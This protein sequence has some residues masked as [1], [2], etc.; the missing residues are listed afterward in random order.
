MALGV[1]STALS[2]ER[3]ER[4]G[5]YAKIL[6]T[7]SV[8]KRDVSRTIDDESDDFYKEGSC[9]ERNDWTDEG[10][11]LLEETLVTKSCN[12]QSSE[13]GRQV[14]NEILGSFSGLN[15][16]VYILKSI[17]SA[18]IDK[19]INFV[20]VISKIDE[21]MTLPKAEQG[22]SNTTGTYW[23]VIGETNDVPI[24]QVM[25]ET[26]EVAKHI[27]DEVIKNYTVEQLASVPVSCVQEKIEEM[28][29]ITLQEQASKRVI[30]QTADILDQQIQESIV[31][32]MK[33]ISLVQQTMEGTVDVPVSQIWKETEKVHPDWELDCL[34]NYVFCKVMD[35]LKRAHDLWFHD[36]VKRVRLE[37]ILEK[38]LEEVRRKGDEPRNEPQPQVNKMQG[39][40][41][42]QL[43]P[44]RYS[45]KVEEAI[46]QEY[47]HQYAEEQHIPM[48]IHTG[49]IQLAE[50]NEFESEHENQNEEINPMTSVYRAGTCVSGDQHNV[51]GT[52]FR[53]KPGVE[54]TNTH[55]HVTHKLNTDTEHPLRSSQHDKTLMTQ[56]S[57]DDETKGYQGHSKGGERTIYVRRQGEMQAMNEQELRREASRNND[58][59]VVYDGKVVSPRAIKYLKNHAIAHVVDKLRGGGRKKNQ[60]KMD[61]T[62]ND[63]SGSSLSEAD[64]FSELLEKFG[65]SNEL[66][67]AML[68]VDDDTIQELMN[69]MRHI[70]EA[71]AGMNR[72]AALD[73]LQRMIKEHRQRA[74]HQQ[75]EAAQEAARRQKQEEMT[76][77][78]DQQGKSLAES[79]EQTQEVRHG[80]KQE[81]T[82]R[83]R[84]QQKQRHQ[85]ARSEVKIG[86]GR[87]MGKTYGS[88]YKEDPGY[89]E[90]V[91]K[92][93]TPNKA[94]I[95]FQG[96]IEEEGREAKRRELIEREAKL[97]ENRRKAELEMKERQQMLQLTRE[98]LESMDV[99]L[100]PGSA[101]ATR[102][103]DDEEENKKDN[104]TAAAARQNDNEEEN[105]KDYTTAAAA[106]QNDNEEE[107]KKDDTAAAA[108]R[109]DN[110]VENEKN[111]T[112]AATR[113]SID[114]IENENMAAARWND[115]KV[116]NMRCAAERQWGNPWTWEEATYQRRQPPY[117]GIGKQKTM[118]RTAQPW[119]RGGDVRIL[120][121][122]DANANKERGMRGKRN[123]KSKYAR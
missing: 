17:S 59:Y 68:K 6:E 73:T 50:D 89:C 52:S 26:V 60:R 41:M 33:A 22:E 12:N 4:V 46:T 35:T 108:R 8:S 103:N 70:Q 3:V 37:G 55:D 101:A 32:V 106:R 79:E 85:N 21:M 5:R 38:T 14:V 76:K 97:E 66:Y 72:G 105:K 29:R 42:T 48:H 11:R 62:Q 23:M 13:R 47:L 121:R 25:E 27:L 115:D 81:G 91:S 2:N 117:W 107:N 44:R 51:Q 16:C 114:E 93:D 112:A 95:E 49:K 61:Q 83:E 34:K 53:D 36:D 64:M 20:K 84:E 109:N 9:T 30:E 111:D 7:K 102:Q 94:I 56:Q 86:F 40:T 74:R 120:A 67:Q 31:E 116:E 88:I 96:F 122:G 54:Y 75:E 99:G 45:A 100:R 123:W 92:L 18:V 77:G 28:I 110:E 119:C 113:W 65:W 43:F 19:N 10:Q 1:V 90:W 98:M 39:E 80:K 104:T 57:D 82:T 58:V 87:Y 63:Q 15:D 78:K 71:D 118:P 69:K 24:T